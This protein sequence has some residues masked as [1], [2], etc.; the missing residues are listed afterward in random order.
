[1][2]KKSKAWAVF[3][4]FGAGTLVSLALFMFLGNPFISPSKIFSPTHSLDHVLLFKARLPRLLLGVFVGMGLST[5]GV[6]FQA[7][8]ANPLADPY[9]LGISGGAALGAVVGL[10]LGLPP[11]MVTLLAFGFA[12]GS[13]VLIYSLAQV[14]GR[15]PTHR[16]LL[17]GVMFNAF[18]FALILFVHALLQMSRSH[19]VFYLLLGSLEVHSW[20]TVLIVGGVTLFGCIL[21]F[22][23]SSKMN[24]IAIGEETAA[25][26]G[27]NVGRTQKIIFLASS[28]VVGASVSVTG[29][30]GFV[31]LFI[32]HVMRLIFGS[33][34]RVLIPASALGGSIFLLCCDFVARTL[35]SGETVQTQL[36]IGVI[37]ALI[38]GPFFLFLLK[39]NARS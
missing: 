33:D 19:E 23:Q 11:V 12:L 14:D 29:L 24:M 4:A 39:K 9:I 28:L 1:M 31:G 16:L 13:L 5:S 20:G 35:F 10:A 15:L 17:T 2:N 38:G 7:L 3:L 26:L 27:V 32:P 34:H 6:S 37:T 18:A 21:L 25:S 22:S 8:L 36:P 30:I